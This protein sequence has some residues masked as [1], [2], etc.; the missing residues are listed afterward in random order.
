MTAKNKKTLVIVCGASGLI[1]KA[2]IEG[3]SKAGTHVVALDIKKINLKVN[4][5]VDSYVI[6]LTKEPDVKS[7]FEKIFKRS[8][9]SDATLIN[10]QAISNPYSGALENLEYKK[11][12]A[13][14][15]KNLDSYFLTSKY[16]LKNKKHFDG[17]S[18]INLSSTRHL[19]AE[20]ETEAYCAT[21]GA[22]VSFSKALAV[23][24]GPKSIR[25]NSISPGWISDKADLTKEDHEQHPSGRVGHGQDVFHLCQYLSDVEL[26]GFVTG[27]D[28]VLD[29]GMTAKMIYK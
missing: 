24:Y 23:T 2:L 5:L 18:V 9:F 11:W 4:P 20:A 15:N 10:C 16:F 1:G 29:G 28:F 25:V 19:M 22:I 27:Q 26:S 14:I 6:D 21:K 3:F 17:G 7:R 8:K 12:K 13:Y